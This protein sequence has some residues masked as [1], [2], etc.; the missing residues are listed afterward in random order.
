MINWWQ[1]HWAQI[2]E[3]A[4]AE[5]SNEIDKKETLDQVFF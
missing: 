3:E 2:L 1:N 4:N 5:S